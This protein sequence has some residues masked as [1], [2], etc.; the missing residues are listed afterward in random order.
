MAGDGWDAGQRT[1]TESGDRLGYGE[2]AGAPVVGAGRAELMA[3]PPMRAP[4]AGGAAPRRLSRRSAEPHDA[5]QF[6]GAVVPHDHAAVEPPVQHPDVV[7]TE[8]RRADRLQPAAQCHQGDAHGELGD[9]AEYEG[10]RVRVHKG[11][12]E[13]SVIQQYL[14]EMQRHRQPDTGDHG[15]CGNKKKERFDPPRE[16]VGAR[17]RRSEAPVTDH[18]TDARSRTRARRL[19]HG[20][21]PDREA[22][23]QVARHHRGGRSAPLT[24]RSA[25]A[26]GLGRA[27]SRGRG[28]R[29]G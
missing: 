13:R 28:C 1:V 22:S 23:P 2:P 27:T 5:D 12:H 4:A 19:P 18:P 14:R 7:G 21:E 20:W 9:K 10:D 25:G 24:R 8:R 6:T 3:S 29:T 16:V 17:P 26:S 11:A 15:Q